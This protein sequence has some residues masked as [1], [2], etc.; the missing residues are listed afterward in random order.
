[1][2]KLLCGVAALALASSAFAGTVV[3]LNEADFVS[4]LQPDFYLET[5]AGSSF[6]VPYNNEPVASLG[7]VNGYSWN[8]TAADAAGLPSGIFSV[9][10]RLSTNNAA[11]ILTITMT[12]APVRAIGGIFESTDFDGLPIAIPVTVNLSNGTQETIN[13]GSG[14]RGFIAPAPILSLTVDAPDQGGVLNWPAI[15][16]FYVGNP[17]PEPASISLLLLAAAFCRRR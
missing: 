9:P 5:F 7:P 4:Q 14:F 13:T 1:M 12:G 17:I 8:A 16:N 10:N 6:G 2:K 11:D 15:G 3:V